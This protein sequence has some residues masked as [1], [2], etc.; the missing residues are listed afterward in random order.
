MS[1][2][3]GKKATQAAPAKTKK[4]S[5]RKKVAKT[6]ARKTPG[7]ATGVKEKAVKKKVV[8]KKAVAKKPVTRTSTKK[9]T[10]KEK[11]APVQEKKARNPKQTGSSATDST[12]EDTKSLSWMSAQ[13]ASALK[14]VKA[15]QAEKGHTILARTRKQ[16]AEKH[17]DDDRL[18]EIAASMPVDDDGLIEFSAEEMLE[19]QPRQIEASLSAPAPL[20]EETSSNPDTAADSSVEAKP[21]ADLAD[22]VV[23]TPV[24]PPQQPEPG[25]Q[26]LVPPPPQPVKRSALFH[27]ALAAGLL[28]SLLLGYYFWPDGDDSKV[29]EN[30]AAVA[31]QENPV[32]ETPAAAIEPD[33]IEPQVTTA[34]E[35]VTAP[36][37]EPEQESF[38]SINERTPAGIP[39]AREPSGQPQTAAAAP[40]E[41]QAAPKAEP[42]PTLEPTPATPQPTVTQQAQPPV[43]PAAPTPA[44]PQP[45]V[46]QQAQPAATTPAPAQRNYRAPV[47]GSYPQQR[48]PAY[49]QRYYR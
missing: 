31:T 1:G 24:E 34:A 12:S 47:Y 19:K 37:A 42:L 5:T 32:I 9:S 3:T 23:E 40:P 46:T 18:I 4:R 26:P 43:Q 7:S 25:I 11:T 22:E 10:S 13:A 28:F 17:I 30:S 20:G 35:L 41:L 16:D 33:P 44:T 45:T 38:E 15:N 8:A 48:Q 27:P 2:T 49:P 6:S 14:A 39:E 36:A 21:K 29:N